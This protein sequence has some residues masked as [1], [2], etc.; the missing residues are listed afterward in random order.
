MPVNEKAG[1]HILIPAYQPRHNLHDIVNNLVK[2][3]PIKGIVVVDD[4]STLEESHLTFSKLE[5]PPKVTVV[6]NNSNMGKGAALKVGMKLLLKHMGAKDV[7]VTAD[8][9]GQH[10]P[11]DIIAVA[12]HAL[13]HQHSTL[14]CR[15]FEGVIPFRSRIGNTLISA[16]LRLLTGIR[17]KDTQTGLR[18]LTQKDCKRMADLPGD[19]YEYEFNC[20]MYLIKKIRKG[21]IQIPITTVY[22]GNNSTSHFNPVVDSFKIYFTFLR[23]TTVSFV[24]AMIDIS[25]FTLLT[26]FHIDTLPALLVSRAV[27]LPVY[28]MGMRNAVFKTHRAVTLPLLGTCLL[29]AINII[30]LWQ[31]I[32]FLHHSFDMY[33][34]L[35]MVIGSTT[36]FV[37]NFL[38]QNYVLYRPKDRTGRSR[39]K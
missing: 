30:Y 38:I 9:D 6:H 39:T 26:L 10:L 36:F 20:L 17:I 14:G 8:A 16:S 37:V 5:H 34:W 7:I 32:E 23:Y 19:G 24:A 3:S 15:Q 21:P 27:S 1:Y 22:E 11:K 28:F 29:I 13:K 35:A 25:T 31:F 12:E 2:G 18:A 4:G 33:R